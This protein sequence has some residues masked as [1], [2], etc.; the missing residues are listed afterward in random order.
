MHFSYVKSKILRR[1]LN[2]LHNYVHSR[3]FF[4][5]KIHPPQTTMPAPRPPLPAT[6]PCPPPDPACHPTL[7]ATPPC[8][9]PYQARH[10]QASHPTLQGCLPRQPCP[11]RQP[12]LRH[13]RCDTLVQ[14]SSSCDGCVCGMQV[15]VIPPPRFYVPHLIFYVPPPKFYV[16]HLIFYLPHLIFY[17]TKYYT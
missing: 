15:N 2:I 16:P 4:T 1:W 5:L 10:Y 12:R 9:P 7:P 8:P 13:E 14:S 3:T 6:R 17:I 11:P